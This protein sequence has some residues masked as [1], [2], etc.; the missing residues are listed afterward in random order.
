MGAKPPYS[1]LQIEKKWQ[2]HWAKQATFLAKQDP[3]KQKMYILDM[4]P[5]P[6]GNGLHVGHC[7]GYVATD[8][9]ARY[10]KSHG[11]N[12]LHPMGFDVFGLPAEQYAIETGQHPAI[13]TQKNITQYK[14]QLKALG[15][16]IDWSRE[17]ST[18]DP[19]YY[20][21]TQWIFLQLFASWYNLAT[22][23]AEPI[24]KLIA[25][26]EEK[27]NIGLQASTHK[28]LPTFTPQAWQGMSE[29]QKE[30]ILHQYR[31]AYLSETIVNWCPALGT[32]LANSEV[33]QGL[34]ERGGHPVI[35]KKMQQWS[36]RITAYADRLLADLDQLDWPDAIKTV[37]KNWIG[38]SIGT[39]I[40]FATHL[41]KAP[42]IH[43]FTTRPETIFGASYIAISPTH[44]IVDTLTQ[45]QEDDTQAPLT[46]FQKK[47][48]AYLAKSEMPAPNQ[49]KNTSGIFTGVY[50]IHPFTQE[51]LPIW[52]TDYVLAAYGTGAL[53]GVPA[54]DSRDHAFAT[55]F[56]LPIKQVI[57]PLEKI[58]IANKA[59]ESKQGTLI[60]SHFLNQLS[61][62]KANEIIIKQLKKNH[63][64]K[65]KVHY[66]LHDAIFSRQ[67][68]WGEP[69]PIYYK[70][71][72]AKALQKAD[73]PLTLPNISAYKPDEKGRPPL[74]RASN[75]QTAEGHPIE[76]NTMPSWAGSS[77]YFLRYTD[78]NN[79]QNLASQQALDYWKEVDLYIGGAEHATG[80][81]IYARFFTKFLYDLDLISLQEPFK[82]LI[83]QGMIQG[84]SQFVYRI[85]N[86]NQ[87]VS[88]RLRHQYDTT[89]LRVAISLVK[90]GIL[91][92]QAFKKWR[93]EF[94][95]A[96]FILENGQYHCGQEVEKMSKSKYNTITPD[97]VIAAYGADTL[98]LYLMFLGPIAQSKPWSTQS[99][100][101][102]YRFLQKV[103]QLFH[104]QEGN[105]SISEQA[106]SQDEHK[107]LHRT[108]QQVKE[109]IARYTFNT[110]ISNMMIGLNDFIRLKCNKRAIL[111]DFLSLLA[112]FAPH[113]TEELWHLMGHT[114]SI[115]LAKYPQHNPAY[116]TTSSITY[117]IAI[118]GKVRTK[119]TISTS[120]TKETIIQQALQAEALAKWLK[121]KSP[122]KT[123]LIQGKMINIVL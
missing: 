61:V 44:P 107:A 52:V 74:A 114:Q 28:D 112:P 103:W 116:L 14:K 96:T 38:K 27:G 65:T 35:Q 108:I 21:W 111:Q 29:P 34:S 20:Q 110:A 37:Q 26:F 43:I 40:T 68:Y 109:S 2:A 4:F 58:D 93:K 120:A 1:F 84:V 82:K 81:L 92:I 59:Y 100:E 80:H 8:I 122:K 64:G 102:V 75:W 123:I 33:K 10:Y 87:F 115:A 51:K 91:D 48:K 41:Q 88:H 72:V 118:N 36:L 121:G 113:I 50:A 106:P 55:H 15:L 63:I 32:V 5:Y 13:T 47:L 94:E 79:P 9:L 67:R 95:N 60:H 117:P 19:A 12:V 71:G 30:N 24:A 97:E 49:T 7:L 23:R 66:K 73:L 76:Y 39:Q 42:H 16:A 78:P 3:K 85:K 119:L 105:F 22:N 101:G 25:I 98:R 90:K 104:N 56:N 18:A 17:I 69:F 54:H 53:M 45:L 11:Y 6:S 62:E 99:I 89:P 70:Q 86:T 31:L 77:W 57:K 83:N 46:H